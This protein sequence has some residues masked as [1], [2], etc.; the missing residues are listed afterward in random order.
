[1]GMVSWIH[2]SNSVIDHGNRNVQDMGQ[3]IKSD[4]NKLLNRYN[5][6][7]KEIL[8]SVLL[9]LRNNSFSF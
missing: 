9:A 1:M 2:D 4:Y 7:S 3:N 5:D 8:P 6:I